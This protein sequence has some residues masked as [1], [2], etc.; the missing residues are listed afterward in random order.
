MMTEQ[1]KS[2]SGTS[3]VQ[4]EALFWNAL[5]GNDHKPSRAAEPFFPS[6]EGGTGSCSPLGGQA[7]PQSEK[8]K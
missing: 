6:T 1:R 3:A 2:L 5:Y 4:E 8:R 7:V